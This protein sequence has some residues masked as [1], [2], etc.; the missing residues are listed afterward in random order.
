MSSSVYLAVPVM[1]VLSILQ[2]AFLTRF[3][4]FGMVPQ[5]PLLVAL[6]WGLLHGINEGVMWAF[7][8]GIALDLFSAG[9]MGASALAFIGGVAVATWVEQALPPNRIFLPPLLAAVATFISL[10]L[11]MLLLRVLGRAIPVQSFLDS[12]PLL[13]LHGGLI[14]PIIWMTGGLERL[15]S[16]RGSRIR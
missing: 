6:A 9:P 12:L 15:V 5:L 8:A 13:M 16:V 2:S 14:L 7:W 11:Y 3:P 10:F 4:M 1:V